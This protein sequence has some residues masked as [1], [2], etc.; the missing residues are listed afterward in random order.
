LNTAVGDEFGAA[1]GISGNTIVVGAD[2]SEGYRGSAYVF[3]KTAG[4]WK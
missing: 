1:V 2:D 3:T 4:G